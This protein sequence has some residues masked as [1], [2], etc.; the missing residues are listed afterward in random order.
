[1]QSG[2]VIHALTRDVIYNAGAENAE[3][4]TSALKVGFP[5]RPVGRTSAL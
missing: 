3:A 4:E 2:S 1:M 5:Q